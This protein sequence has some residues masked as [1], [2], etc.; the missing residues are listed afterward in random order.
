MLLLD[1]LTCLGYQYPKSMERECMSMKFGTLSERELKIV[2]DLDGIQDIRI[3]ENGYPKT[4]NFMIFCKV[5][6]QSMYC[7]I[8][9]TRGT[10]K[11]FKNFHTLYAYLRTNCARFVESQT[12]KDLA[13]FSMSLVTEKPD[14]QASA[15]KEN[16]KVT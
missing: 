8:M 14:V 4:L 9:T 5:R 12:S 15:E 7:A 6:N 13:F 10:I 1:I 3:F 11:E 16:S 2:D